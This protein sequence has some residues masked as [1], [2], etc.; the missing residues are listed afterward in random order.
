MKETFK[1]GKSK[2]W[3]TMLGWVASYPGTRGP[4]RIANFKDS[5]ETAKANLQALINAREK[6]K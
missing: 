4:K 6:T 2:C 5:E 3:W 1:I